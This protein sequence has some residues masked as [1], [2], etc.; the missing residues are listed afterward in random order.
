MADITSRRNPL[1]QKLRRL[2]SDPTFRRSEKLF[3]ADG[4]KLLADALR[5]GITPGLVAITEGVNPP[6]LP[7]GTLLV[8]LSP[9]VMDA[10]SPSETPQ[11]LL[12]TV[13]LPDPP[14]PVPP[15]RGKWLLLD[16]IQDPGNVGSILRTAEA[17]ALDGALLTDGCA[18]PF[19]PKAVRA[20]MGAVFRL[21]IATAPVDLLLS[22]TLTLVAAGFGDD[23]VP[24]GSVRYTDCVVAL[25]NEGRGLRPDIRE[26]AETV[27]TIPMKGR[28]ESLGVAAAA[29]ILCWFLGK[30]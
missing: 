18:D 17:F 7:D 16:R 4:P 6:A 27:V 5:S 28:A 23:A 26:R 14:K 25:G 24:V 1:I 22:G 13:P 10:V 19:S 21:P 15:E 11:G 8:T 20:S 9:G 3:L 29:A 12:F 30:G 2:A